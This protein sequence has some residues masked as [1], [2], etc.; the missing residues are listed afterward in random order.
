MLRAADVGDAKRCF[1]ENIIFKITATLRAGV[2][3]LASG[4][5]DG[6]AEAEDDAEANAEAEDDSVRRR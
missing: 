1:R 4:D 2:C 6:E 5:A 3:T